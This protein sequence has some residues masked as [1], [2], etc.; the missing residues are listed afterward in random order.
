MMLQSLTSE[1]YDLADAM[2]TQH[3]L[4][5]PLSLQGQWVVPLQTRL[6]THEQSIGVPIAPPGH[7]EHRKCDSRFG[8]S[9]KSVV[10]KEGSLVLGF[11]P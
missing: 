9:L 7:A 11:I 1:Q 6:Q 8:S 2:G 10:M 4:V 5:R 3:S